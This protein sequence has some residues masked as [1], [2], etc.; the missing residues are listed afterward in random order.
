MLI[1]TNMIISVDLMKFNID[2]SARI[3]WNINQIARNIGI[4]KQL[5]FMHPI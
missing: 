1:L 5:N 3:I 4:L 2:N